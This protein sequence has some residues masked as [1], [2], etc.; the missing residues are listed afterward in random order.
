MQFKTELL[1]FHLQEL[2]TSVYITRL[3]LRFTHTEKKIL[4]YLICP[5]YGMEA[6][7][8][9]WSAGFSSP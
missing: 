1:K 8:R 6:F 2:G 3:E 5:N 9:D 4:C 7:T